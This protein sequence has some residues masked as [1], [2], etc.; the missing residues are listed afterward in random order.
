MFRFTRCAT[1]ANA[2]SIPAAVGFSKEVCGYI[3]KTYDLHLKSGIEL[4][5]AS[6]IHWEMESDSLDKLTALYAKLLGDKTYAS[7]LDKAKDLWVDGSL[8][9]QIVQWV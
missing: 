5:G 3:N 9:D 7:M 8:K 6:V 2:N 1:L 4:F